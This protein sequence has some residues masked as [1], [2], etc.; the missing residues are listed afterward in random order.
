MR[1]C[2]PGRSRNTQGPAAATSSERLQPAATAGSRAAGVGSGQRE[3]PFEPRNSTHNVLLI[4]RGENKS[5]HGGRCKGALEP[6]WWQRAAASAW[7]ARGGL[8]GRTCP[9]KA[10]GRPFDVLLGLHYKLT[11]PMGQRPP[12]LRP[13]RHLFVWDAPQ[14]SGSP[15]CLHTY[16]GKNKSCFSLATLREMLSYVSCRDASRAPSLDFSGEP[17]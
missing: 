3:S 15:P 17:T 1:S 12:P 7:A 9:G 10:F 8:A 4:T 14:P 16:Q 5:Q 2:E 11:S 6:V 13:G